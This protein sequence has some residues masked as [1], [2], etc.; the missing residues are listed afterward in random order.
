[1]P[2]YSVPAVTPTSQD[3]IPAYVGP[4]NRLTAKHGG[5]HLA[6]TDSHERLEG[7]GEGAALRII[8]EWPSAA[9]LSDPEFVPH[10]EAR[11][12]GASGHSLLIEGQDD[13]Q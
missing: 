8:I 4:A 10:L 11:L 7:A 9:F 2:C 6:R 1:M 5:K 12:A 13:L 3:W